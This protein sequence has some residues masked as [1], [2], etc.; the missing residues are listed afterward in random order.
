MLIV[1]I[2]LPCYVAVPLSGLI[3]CCIIFSMIVNALLWLH[4]DLFALIVLLLNWLILTEKWY[5]KSSDK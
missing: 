3:L 4:S 5:L 1:M 2:V